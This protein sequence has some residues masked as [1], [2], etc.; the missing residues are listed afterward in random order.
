MMKNFPQLRVPVTGSSQAFVCPCSLGFQGT[1]RARGEARRRQGTDILITGSRLER[2][3]ST[4]CPTP[5]SLASCDGAESDR[6]TIA[7]NL[8]EIVDVSR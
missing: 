4:D 8:G 7:L 6:R 2:L 3:R 1:F 5:D